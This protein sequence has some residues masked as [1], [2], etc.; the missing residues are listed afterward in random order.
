M[1]TCSSVCVAAAPG[2]VGSG[3]EQEGAQKQMVGTH[4]VRRPLPSLPMTAANRCCSVLGSRVRPRWTAAW[5]GSAIVQQFGAA[6]PQHGCWLWLLAGLAAV[7][8]AALAARRRPWVRWSKPGC[9][10]RWLPPSLDPGSAASS[11]AERAG[12][13]DPAAAPLKQ[14]TA[15]NQE[16]REGWEGE[17]EAGK[18]GGEVTN[19]VARVYMCV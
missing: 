5:A 16:K 3:V 15:H 12:R 8:A 18:R 17:G 2:R 11:V 6:A 9:T 10:A 19:A 4:G 14:G 13:R 7:A 1:P